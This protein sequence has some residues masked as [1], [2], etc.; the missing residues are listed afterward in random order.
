MV[1]FGFISELIVWWVRNLFISFVESLQRCRKSRGLGERQGIMYGEIR[2]K[3][4]IAFFTLMSGVAFAQIAPV[5]RIQTAS[6]FLEVCGSPDTQMS[7]AQAAALK[8]A[9]PSEMA[10]AMSKQMDNRMAEVMMCF[11]YLAGLTEGWKEG[12]EHGV[13]AAQFPKGW[14]NDVKKGLAHLPLKQVETVQAAMTVDVPCIPDS[15]TIG[16]ERDVVVK[17]IRKDMSLTTA[18]T[19]RVVPLAFREAFPCSAQPPTSK[20]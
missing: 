1:F 5:S 12:H 10:S 4:L 2:M 13:V 8:K 16:E 18:L 17:F 15:T 6:G 11:G 3:T 9:S 7:A 19:S 14:P 20:H